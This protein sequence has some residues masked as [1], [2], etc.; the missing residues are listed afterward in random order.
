MEIYVGK[1]FVLALNM[2]VLV[3]LQ[4]KIEVSILTLNEEND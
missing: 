2:F 3:V 1:F 4:H